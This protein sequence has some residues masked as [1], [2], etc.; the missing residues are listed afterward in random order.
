MRR[1]DSRLR[2]TAETLAAR[3]GRGFRRLR[4]RAFWRFGVPSILVAYGLLFTFPGC[5]FAYH[6]EHRA[7]R[8]HCDVPP[9][10]NLVH[11]LDD[12]EARLA[13]STIHDPGLVHHLY[14]CNGPIRRGLLAPTLRGAFGTTYALS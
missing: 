5:L 1:F 12:A 11:V 8:V 10:A 13:R 6:V 2:A 9:S 14:L 7:F 4:K 3:L